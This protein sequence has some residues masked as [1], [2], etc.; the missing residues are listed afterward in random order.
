MSFLK[1]NEINTDINHYRYTFFGV[2]GSGKT[3]TAFYFFDDPIFFA[4]E[5]G[6]KTLEAYIYD[7]YTWKDL[8][9]F[10]KKARKELKEDPDSELKGKV[11]I[12]DTAELMGDACQRYICEMNNWDDPS[13]SAYGSAY[14]IIKEE[15]NKRLNEL[16]EL[17]FKVSFITHEKTKKTSFKSGIEYEK[18]IPSL[19]SSTRTPVVDRVDTVMYFTYDYDTNEDGERA[20]KRVVY[21][22]G[23]DT[24]EAK[25]RI[26][27]LPERVT[28]KSSP[29]EAGEQLRKMLEEA[30]KNQKKGSTAR[31][32]NEKKREREREKEKKKLEQIRQELTDMAMDLYKRKIVS[33][34]DIQRIVTENTSVSKMEEIEDF[35]ELSKVEKSLQSLRKTEDI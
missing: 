30:L 24:I 32:D 21:F 31:E 14:T 1:R 5:Q 6:Q 20:R 17:G 3:S 12:M 2:A 16:E 18:I 35:E 26:V 34:E 13:D 8:L 25:T 9:T 11:I 10:I 4:W 29:E 27:G 22:N 28:L 33:A 15:L 7:C 23:G 19:N